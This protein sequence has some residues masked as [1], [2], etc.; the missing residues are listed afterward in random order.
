MD[1][2]S[3]Y[4]SD[5]IQTFCANG[6]MS[7]P[8]QSVLGPVLFI[9]YTEDIMLIFNS[10]VNHH[11][12]ADNKQA[13]VSLPV[14]NVLLA[15]QTLERCIS[16][17]AS[18]CA[19]RRLQLNAAKTELIWFG[20]LQMPEKLTD[21]DLTLDTGTTVIRPLKSIHDLGI[22]LDSELTMKTHISKVVSCCYHCSFVEFA[23]FAGSSGKM[24]LNIW[25]QHSFYRDS[26]TA[27]HCCLVCQ[28]QLFSPCSM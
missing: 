19:S 20:F 26:T 15:R 22:Y 11:L 28:G 5:W 9:S 18:W 24:S 3:S 12:Y 14:N 1:W 21:S 2:F 16:D 23:R 27:T 8:I 10:Q 25:F 13:Y 17:I 4:L 6:V 7:G